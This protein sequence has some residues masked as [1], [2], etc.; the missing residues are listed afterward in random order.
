MCPARIPAVTGRKG[1]EMLV[2][3]NAGDVE[4]LLQSLQYSKERVHNAKDTPDSV[5]KENLRKLDVIADKLRKAA[6]P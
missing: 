2:D 3:L 6:G 1:D 5:R 4:V